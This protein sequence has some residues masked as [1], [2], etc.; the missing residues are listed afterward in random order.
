MLQHYRFRKMSD[1]ITYNK[2]GG[3]P[4]STAAHSRTNKERDRNRIYAFIYARGHY[5]A[6]ADEVNHE[7]F[8]GTFAPTVSARFSDLK[9]S[10]DLVS[11]GTSRRTRKQCAAEVFVCKLFAPPVQS[12][13]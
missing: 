11:A 3:N 13:F 2:H 7:L 1:D 9:K 4:F 12:L 6:T 5:G 10:G 8:G